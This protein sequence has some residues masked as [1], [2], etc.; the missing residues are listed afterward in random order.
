LEGGILEKWRKKLQKLSVHD[1]LDIFVS[2]E[3]SQKVSLKPEQTDNQLFHEVL[4][5]NTL[6][7]Y[8]RITTEIMEERRN[9]FITL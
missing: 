6:K 9:A 2:N 8:C 4:R 1:L 3:I 5:Q 7:Q